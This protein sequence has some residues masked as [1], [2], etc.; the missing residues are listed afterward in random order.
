MN[1]YDNHL[2]DVIGNAVYYGV[3]DGINDVANNYA[4]N[5]LDCQSDSYYLECDDDDGYYC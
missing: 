5:Y 2:I 3:R 1:G 4:Q